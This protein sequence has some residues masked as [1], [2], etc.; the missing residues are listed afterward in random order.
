V[1]ERMVWHFLLVDDEY[2]RR[3]GE[4]IGISADD[5]RGLTPLSDQKLTDEDRRRLDALGHAGR[6]RQTGNQITGSVPV[7]RAAE[8]PDSAAAALLGLDSHDGENGS[9]AKSAP[10][11]ETVASASDRG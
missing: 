5:V 2:G 9:S 8:V 3:V 11:M 1:Q 7:M 10:A 6:R 4:G